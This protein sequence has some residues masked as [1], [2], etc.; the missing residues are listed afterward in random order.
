MPDRR[1]GDRDRLSGGCDRWHPES[2]PV[3][4]APLAWLGP[5]LSIVPGQLFAAA[6]AGARGLDPDRPRGLAKVTVVP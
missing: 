2:I 6:L 5:L 3:P 1:R 4:G